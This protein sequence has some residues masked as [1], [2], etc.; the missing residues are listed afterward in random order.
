MKPNMVGAGAGMN[1]CIFVDDNIKNI[2][3]LLPAVNPNLMT[4]TYSPL[5]LWHTK[6]ATTAGM[7]AVHFQGAADLE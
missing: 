4:N 1:N 7:R 6:A 2:E 5:G 3:C